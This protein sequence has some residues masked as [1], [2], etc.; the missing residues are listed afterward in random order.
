MHNVIHGN[1]KDGIL[2]RAQR[3]H[4]QQSSVLERGRLTG[5]NGITFASGDNH[6]IINN[7]VHGNYNGGIRLGNSTSAPVFSTVLNNI[8]VQNQVGIREPAGSDYMGKAILDY[9]KVYSNPG[10]NYVLSKSAGSKAGPH[11]I[12]LDPVFVASASHDFR[13][14]RKATGQAADSPAIDRG[15]IRLRIWGSVDERR[16]PTSTRMWGGGPGLP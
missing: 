16:S 3:D 15:L 6:Q 14:G 8:V 9:N 4:L 13:L 5:E 1:G 2:L 12:S 7:T 11:S 10:G